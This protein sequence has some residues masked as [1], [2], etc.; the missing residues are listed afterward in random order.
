MII[1]I[2]FWGYC[3]IGHKRLSDATKSQQELQVNILKLLAIEIID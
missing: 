1:Y 2:L 3:P